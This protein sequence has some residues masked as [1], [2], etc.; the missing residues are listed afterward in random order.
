MKRQPFKP[1]K[2]A[3]KTE[4]ASLPSLPAANLPFDPFASRAPA[5]DDGRVLSA[6]WTEKSVKETYQ[7]GVN[8]KLGDDPR[9]LSALLSYGPSFIPYT[10]AW[11]TN[12]IAAVRSFKHWVYVCVDLIASKVA[13]QYPN[14]SWIRSSVG[15]DSDPEKAWR[16]RI[17]G[18]HFRQ[19]ALTPLLTH[20]ELEPVPSNHPL[21]RLLRDP[22]DPDTAYDLFYETVLFLLLT[23]SAYW[24]IPKNALGLP[25]AV[26]VVPSHWVWPIMGAD[27]YLAGWEIRPVEGNYLKRLLPYDEVVEFKFKNP[28][29][30]L[31][32]FGPLAACSEWVD[33]VGAVNRAMIRSYR[34]GPMPTVAVEF[35]ASLNDPNPNVLSRIEQKFLS[36]YAGSEHAGQTI[37]M[38]PGTKLRPLVIKAN[39]MIFGSIG[40]TLRNY[41]CSSFGVPNELVDIKGDTTKA[42]NSLYNRKINP[43][44]HFLGQVISEKVAVRYP[45]DHGDLRVWWEKFTAND[46]ELVNNNHKVDLLCGALTP[47]ERRISQGREPYKGELEKFGN[48]PFLPVNM[49]S[50]ALPGGG[51]HTAKPGDKPDSDYEHPALNDEDTKQLVRRNGV[52]SSLRNGPSNER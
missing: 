16:T 22:N 32:G 46:P 12:R 44:S 5:E 34:N 4:S 40:D 39:E 15:D 7:K 24:W 2:R 8:G 48:T 21:Q 49:E 31:D 33:T 36:R 14:V 19:K 18:P 3:R 43:L 10:A 37:F 1:G 45:Q 9:D 35:D 23:G 29:S 20:E 27:K 11:T 17:L 28:I 42:E 30:K 6:D 50:G 26:W 38:P 41:I 51:D 52:L 25:A 13:S 47:N